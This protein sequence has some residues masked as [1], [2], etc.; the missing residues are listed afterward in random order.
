M[1]GAKLHRTRSLCGGIKQSRGGEKK[2]TNKKQKI[3][4]RANKF[5]CG[6]L[7]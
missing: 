5:S 3:K 6:I 4:V 7:P 1:E 2:Q